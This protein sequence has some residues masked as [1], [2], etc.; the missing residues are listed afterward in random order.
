MKKRLEDYLGG[1]S[2]ELNYLLE[3][4]SQKNAFDFL[5]TSKKGK[6]FRTDGNSNEDFYA[7]G[8]YLFSPCDG[9]I[10]SVVNCVKEKYS[11]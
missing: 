2:K 1:D 6:S 3:S 8:Q 11:G 7:F 5:M 9:E 10:V 4:K